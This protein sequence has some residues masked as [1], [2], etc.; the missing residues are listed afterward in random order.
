MKN[1]LSQYKTWILD[2]DG[3][4]YHQLPLRI[5]MAMMLIIYYIIRPFRINEVFIIRDYRRLREQLFATNSKDFHQQQLQFLSNKYKMP[6]DEIKQ[7]IHLWLIEKPLP[8]IKMW[9]RK[10]LLSTIKNYQAQGVQ[11]FVY[12]DNPVDEKIAALDFLPNKT[13]CSDDDIIHCMKPDSTGLKNILKS[14]N[15]N[16]REVLYIG[17]R[18]D[19]DKLCAEDAG[20]DY[21]DVS[22]F[23]QNF[24]N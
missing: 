19:R 10:K 23:E 17:D 12:S 8:L 1:K 5:C 16:P 14:Y 22:D 6:V 15:L 4:L 9:Q 21:C 13:F 18:D 20:V 24:C 3:T 7:L 2:F 11:M